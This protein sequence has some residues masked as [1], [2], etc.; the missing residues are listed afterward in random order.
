MNEPL[1]QTDQARLRGL[2]QTHDESKVKDI[3]TLWLDLQHV[4]FKGDQFY[5]SKD[6]GRNII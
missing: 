6:Y 4:D 1:G 5:L 2:I 3:D